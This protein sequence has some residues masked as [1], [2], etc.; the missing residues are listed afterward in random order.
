MELT[1]SSTSGWAYRDIHHWEEQY[2]QPWSPHYR[3]RIY[4]M[5][6]HLISLFLLF[7]IAFFNTKLSYT[8]ISFTIHSLPYLPHS[9]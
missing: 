7:Y 2:S 3:L 9:E 4:H 1:T 5:R 8:G 6:G